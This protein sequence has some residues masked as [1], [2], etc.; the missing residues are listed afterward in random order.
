MIVRSVCVRDF[1]CLGGP[2]EAEFGPGLNVIVGPNES[3]K[4][5]LLRAI[6]GV[7]TVK[8]TATG[9]TL[10]AIRPHTGGTPEVNVVFEQDGAT[11]ELSKQFK[12]A[13]GRATLR[14]ETTG[15]TVENLADAAA[16]ERLREV[17]GM[18][19]TLRQ[20][21]DSEAH[22]GI[23]PLLWVKQGHSGA[24][25]SDDLTESARGTL[26]DRLSELSGEVL[27]GAGGEELLRRAKGEYDRYFTAQGK[28]ATRTDSPL[29]QARTALENAADQLAELQRREE[30]HA[31]DV[32]EFARLAEQ[33]DKLERQLPRLK[34]DRG[35]A[36]EAARKVELLRGDRDKTAADLRTVTIQLEQIDQKI[37]SRA[38]LREQI[39]AHAER[40]AASVKQLDSAR[41]RLADHDAA[42]PPLETAARTADERR[43][44]LERQWRRCHRHIEL[45]QFKRRA[46]ETSAVLDRVRD[47]REKVLAAEARIAA[48]TVTDKTVKRLTRLE[49][50]GR[51]SRLALEAAAAGVR[52]EAIRDVTI[53]IEGHRVEL[54]AG[55]TW[56]R[57]AAAPLD[58]EIDAAA[59]VRVTPGG[60]ELADLAGA[61]DE[62][63][64]KLETAL[65]EVGVP[66]VAEARDKA[67]TIRELA[68]ERASHRKMIEAIAPDGIDELETREASLSAKAR[69]AAEQLDALSQDDDPPLP[70]DLAEVERDRERVDQQHAG[71][72]RLAEE[73]RDRLVHHDKRRERLDA[74][75]RLAEQELAAGRDDDKR[76]QEA[77]A[78]SVRQHGDDDLLAAEYEKTNERGRRVRESIVQL[79]AELED[80]SAARVADEADR[81]DRTLQSAEQELREGEKRL[82]HLRESLTADDLVGLHERID[83]ARAEVVREEE[84]MAREQRAARAAG[85]LYETLRSCRDEVRQRYLAPLQQTVKPLLEI[86]FPDATI[87][88]DERFDL[89][90]LNRREADGFGELS[91]G[92]REQVGVVVRLAMAM[93]LAGDHPLTVML[94]DALVATDDDRFKRM[95]AVLQRCATRLQIILATCHWDRHRQLGVD[96]GQVLR[97]K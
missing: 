46:A 66:S 83:D 22:L 59:R 20:R 82:F 1:G 24:S 50:E 38:G 79:D 86:L 40:I 77:L 55:Q 23:W 43:E 70:D 68:A 75:R 73:A 54:E 10:D 47:L 5:T 49:D 65:A 95:A 31:H 92:C 93:V 26:A 14:V 72:K 88:F 42:R 19:E 67:E 29:R 60:A 94:D 36:Q 45:L 69:G 76:S 27:A 39:A 16:E 96:R 3:G 51:R 34:R 33:A 48:E 89:E 87:D 25:P 15:G 52:V 30:R 57:S 97:L 17:L 84:T 64:R 8:T 9:Q 56:E 63:R 71:Q 62:A 28:E 78:R 90:R 37:A 6:A 85:L 35:A 32:D 53:I 13:R 21:I 80:L 4:T 91:E 18:R 12:G 41:Q 7:L 61:A 58:V 81:A 44:R 74:D 2:V 11:Y